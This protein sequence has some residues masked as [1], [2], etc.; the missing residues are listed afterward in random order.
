MGVNRALVIATD[1]GEVNRGRRPAVA[2]PAFEAVAIISNGRRSG[3]SVGQTNLRVEAR[4][5]GLENAQRDFFPG[6]IVEQG[7]SN[8]VK[9]RGNHQFDETLGRIKGAHD[10]QTLVRP[11]KVAEQGDIATPHLHQQGFIAA[12]AAWRRVRRSGP[13]LSPSRRFHLQ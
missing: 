4:G 5:R 8:V 11:H 1:A 7:Q 9:R 2:Q 6:Q 10:A 13:N 12:L 3:R